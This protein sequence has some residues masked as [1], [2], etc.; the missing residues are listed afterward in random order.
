MATGHKKLPRE[1]DP[2][3]FAREGVI[4]DVTIPQQQMKRL[5]ELLTHSN[6]E[7]SAELEFGV[8]FLGTH[9]LRGHLV[10][11]VELIC[12]R[13][14]ESMHLDLD[15]NLSLGFAGNAEKAESIPTD[16]DAI[17]V[18][19][20]KIVLLDLLEDEL[21]LALPQI[22]RHTQ[23]TCSTQVGNEPPEQVEETLSEP[24]RENPFAVLASLKKSEN[25]E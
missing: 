18:D 23:E 19:N 9:F 5:Q 21:L 12:Q 11:Q 15:I 22:P 17:I 4:L 10:T 3:R 24:E 25:G 13:C 16:Y 2:F 8:D 7:V 14:L 1:V 6:N 20:A